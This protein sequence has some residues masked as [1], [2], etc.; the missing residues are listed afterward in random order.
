MSHGIAMSYLISLNPKHFKNIAHV[1]SFENVVFLYVHICVFFQFRFG[2]A[3]CI[4]I[5]RQQ[6]CLVIFDILNPMLL[7]NIYLVNIY[8]GSNT[9]NLT[10]LKKWPAAAAGSIAD[11]GKH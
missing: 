9:P 6:C 3:I 5:V 2:N 11:Q 7:K 1:R 8:K 10:N 4:E